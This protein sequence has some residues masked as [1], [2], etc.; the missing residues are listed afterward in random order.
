MRGRF[1]WV[2]LVGAWASELR[3]AYVIGTWRCITLGR[4][5]HVD[6]IESWFHADLI[7]IHTIYTY[8]SQYMCFENF[9]LHPS[10][11]LLI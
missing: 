4:G 11:E 1:P 5:A 9:N 10:T 8:T 7:H 6:Y 2:D 3:F